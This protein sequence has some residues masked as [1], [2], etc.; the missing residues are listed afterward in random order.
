M[1]DETPRMQVLSDEMR[2]VMAAWIKE[3]KNDALKR[4][5]LGLQQQYQQLFLAYKRSQLEADAAA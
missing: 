3:P 4:Q 5:Y 1:R 2:V